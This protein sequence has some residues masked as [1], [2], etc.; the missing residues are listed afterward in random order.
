[1]SRMEQKSSYFTSVGTQV[2]VRL[3]PVLRSFE[4]GS[5]FCLFSFLL[6]LLYFSVCAWARGMYPSGKKKMIERR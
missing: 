6:V 2:P 4:T 1:M 3:C 5:S